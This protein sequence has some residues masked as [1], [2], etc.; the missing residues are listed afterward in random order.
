MADIGNRGSMPMKLYG[1]WRSGAAWRVRIALNLK[2]IA[3]ESISVHLM[4]D[5]GE[6]TKPAYRA[7]NPQM[8]VP[9]LVLDDGTVL[10]QSPA[11]LEWIEEAYPMPPLLPSD[12]RTRAQIRGIAG[13][14]GCDVHPLTNAAGTL[15]Y[16]RQTNKLDEAAILAWLTQ[17]TRAGFTAVEALIGD[18]PFSFG[19]RPTLAD[20]Y[21][22]PQLAA[23]RR[24]NVPVDDFARIN[25]IAAH[26]A[27]LE[28][29]KDAA[30]E[31]Q[32]D[33]E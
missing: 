16:L 1:Y 11:I 6:H 28:A 4:R 22:V 24:F 29:F 32:P 10:V 15:K 14:I 17:W 3:Y 33:R 18:G 27:T 13:I 25:R 21:I 20:I 12:E 26:C 23:A 2:G 7:V 19:D 31:S 8:R 9:S 30:P 5:G